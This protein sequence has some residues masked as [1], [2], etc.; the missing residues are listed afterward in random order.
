MQFESFYIK[1]DTNKAFYFDLKSSILTFQINESGI[2]DVKKGSID[3]IKFQQ[4]TLLI[5]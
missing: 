4:K 1:N 3:R 2:S 5:L